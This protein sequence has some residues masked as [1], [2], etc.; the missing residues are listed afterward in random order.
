MQLAEVARV[1]VFHHHL[2]ILE[3]LQLRDFNVARSVKS[4]G[5][6]ISPETVVKTSV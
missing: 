6:R 5:Y 3:F 2:R 4:P 1:A